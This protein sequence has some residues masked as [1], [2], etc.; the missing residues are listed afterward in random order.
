MANVRIRL[1]LRPDQDG[2]KGLRAQYGDRLVCEIPLRRAK[3]ETGQD[4]GMSGSRRKVDALRSAACPGTDRYGAR[5][6]SRDNSPAAGKK[7]RWAV[8]CS[9]ARVEAE[10]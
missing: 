2:A 6:S 3:A 5:L 9:T 4:G 7:C 10:I 1:T 8:G